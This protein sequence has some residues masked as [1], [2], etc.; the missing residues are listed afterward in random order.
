MNRRK[1][2][3]LLFICIFLVFSI[4]AFGQMTAPIDPGGE[5]EGSD[6]PLGGGAPIGGGTIVMLVM[7][8]AYGGKKAFELRKKDK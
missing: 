2:Y 6:P 8:A 7:A 5:P 1:F 3:N 4:T